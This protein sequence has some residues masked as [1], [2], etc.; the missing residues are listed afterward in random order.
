[1]AQ[2]KMTPLMQQYFA[3]KAQY[4]DALLLFQVGDFYELFFDDAKKAAECLRITL[5][6]RGMHMA[7]SIPLCGVPISAV[8]HYVGKLVRAGFKVAMCDQ[9]EPATPGV[10]VKRGVVRVLTPGTLTDDE[11]LD[12]KTASYLCSFFPAQNECGLIFGELLT[13]QLYATVIPVERALILDAELS[14]FFPDE[15]IVPQVPEAKEFISYLTK[16]GYYTSVV[17]FGQAEWQPVTDWVTEQFPEHVVQAFGQ[18]QV[19]ANAMRTFHTYLAKYQA[20]SLGQFKKCHIYAPEDFLLMDVSTQRHLELVKNMQDGSANNTLCQLMDQSATGAGS[21]LIK[22]WIVRPLVK[23]SAI[24]KRQEVVEQFVRSHSLST[25]VLQLLKHIGDLE[26]VVGRIAIQRGGVRDY[27]QLKRSLVFLPELKQLLM[28]TGTPLLHTLVDM[29]SDF[30]Q[31]CAFLTQALYDS[32]ERDWIINQGFDAELDRV[33]GLVHNSNQLI[34]ELEQ[35]EQQATGISSLKIRYNGLS[36]YF[37]E[38]T[39]THSNA[40]PNHYKKYQSLVGKERYITAELKELEQNITS[41]QAQSELLEQ[42]IF[43]ALKVTVH[44]HVHNLRHAAHALAHIDALLGFAHVAYTNGYVKPVISESRDIVITQGR[45]PVVEQQ[46]GHRFI[47]NDAMLTD[48]QSTWIITGPNMGGKSTFLRQVALMTIMGQCGSF[49]PAKRAQLALCDK[50]FT[51]IGASD[52][53]AQGK[54]TFLVEMEE[55]AHICSHATA[56]S[57]VILDEVGRGT[58]TFDGMAI[59]QAVVE[60]VHNTL[61][62]RCLFATHYHELTALEG[63]FA[64]VVNYY[65]ASRKTANGMLLL[66][67]IL[68]GVADGSF[69][70]EVAKAVQLPT[71]LVQ[72]A[73]AILDDLTRAEYAHHVI[74]GQNVLPI[75]GIQQQEQLRRHLQDVEEQLS[76]YKQRITAL[77][78]LDVNN[79]SP[80]QAFDVLWD[81]KSKSTSSQ[82]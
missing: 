1:M 26:R 17:P 65:A 62:A 70:I 37:I 12:A 32:D 69:G 28:S 52:N 7:E 4:A 82:L 43:A 27:V 58:S 9:L 57:L 45:H 66:Y 47:P 31:L 42:K 25:Q 34:C 39:K 33:R 18:Q 23:K 22:K 10:V 72:R 36:G 79:L 30:S 41:A 5:T 40:V 78:N 71:P 81:F 11:L 6:S 67:T 74:S 77:E 63:A 13:A 59:A 19:F 38:I 8:Q 21:R 20:A 55:T 49:V 64:G 2:E 44:E 80:K 29:L 48:A 24:E 60:Y 75:A 68:K 15:I 14:R 53:V 73:Q 56:Q 16:Q 35:A 54:S 76:Y 51:R 46:L 61:K 3:I 50:I